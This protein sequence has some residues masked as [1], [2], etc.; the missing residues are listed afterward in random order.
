[1]AR[2]RREEEASKKEIAQPKNAPMLALAGMAGRRRRGEGKLTLQGG[3]GGDLGRDGPGEVVDVEVEV[4]EAGEGGEL[5]GERAGEAVVVEVQP[6]ERR[7]PGDGGRERPGE[8]FP[9]QRDVGDGPRGAVARHA[10]EPAA[11]FAPARVPPRRPR[12]QQPPRGV[13][14]RRQVQQ[15]PHLPRARR[16]RRARAGQ[17]EDDDD[18]GRGRDEAR[19]RHW[20][21]TRAC[22]RGRGEA[23]EERVDAS[24]CSSSGGRSNNADGT[25]EG[26][27][28][29]GTHVSVGVGCD[30]G[31]SGVVLL[32][33]LPAT[34]KPAD[35]VHKP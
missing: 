11:A 24:E 34:A 14:P 4:G 2:R 16:A 9:L 3:H 23:F 22:R 35:T 31:T 7:E 13:Q 33:V 25:R 19:C 32:L 17:D 27:S 10:L 28:G 12:R 1:M 18:N 20:R 26:R 8:P 29:G 6:R 21:E 5:A 30:D 15:R